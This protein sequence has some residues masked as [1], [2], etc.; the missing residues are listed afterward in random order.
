MEKK[1]H[2]FELQLTLRIILKQADSRWTDVQGN[3]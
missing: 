2:H 3:I 1:C